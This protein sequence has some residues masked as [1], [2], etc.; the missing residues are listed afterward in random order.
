MDSALSV[1]PVQIKDQV[2]FSLPI[3][4]DFAFLLEGI[5]EIL[6]MF[7]ANILHSEIIHANC[8]RD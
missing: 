6:V 8:E 7:L 1:V 5:H 4:G 2:S 3:L